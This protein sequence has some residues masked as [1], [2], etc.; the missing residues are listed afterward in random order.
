MSFIL[1][2]LFSFVSA[3]FPLFFEFVFRSSSIHIIDVKRCCI[4]IYIYRKI[5]ITIINVIVDTKLLYISSFSPLLVVFFCLCLRFATHKNVFKQLRIKYR[6]FEVKRKEMYV[7]RVENT[8]RNTVS[9]RKSV[10]L[11]RKER[12]R[13]RVLLKVNKSMYYGAHFFSLHF[14]GV[15][16]RVHETLYRH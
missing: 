8:R 9:W 10:W 4:T 7:E 16:V 12:E 15:Q 2:I 13:R 5:I 11:R 3:S 1:F 14:N 6:N